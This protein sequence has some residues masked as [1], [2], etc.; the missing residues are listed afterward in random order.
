[1]AERTN[2]TKDSEG[3]ECAFNDEYTWM[4]TFEDDTW[5]SLAFIAALIQTRL[6][7]LDEAIS[8]CQA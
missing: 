6:I 5:I 4:C 7:Q 2:A 1:M 8:R 3:S